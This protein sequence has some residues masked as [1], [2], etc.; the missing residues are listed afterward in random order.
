[1]RVGQGPP[2][3]DA[4]LQLIRQGLSF[5]IEGQRPCH[6]FRPV[7]AR[8]DLHAGIGVVPRGQVAGHLHDGRI[9]QQQHD[10]RAVALAAHDR[11]GLDA[12][13]T[14]IHFGAARKQDA[15]MAAQDGV[16]PGHAELVVQHAGQHGIFAADGIAV[17]DQVAGSHVI[18][19]D[20]CRH[21]ASGDVRFEGG[22]TPREGDALRIEA[23]HPLAIAPHFDVVDR[24]RLEF[25]IERDAEAGQFA[26]Q[27]AGAGFG[28]LF[29]ERHRFAAAAV[30]L[31]IEQPDAPVGAAIGGRLRRPCR[32]H[33]LDPYPF[34]SRTGGEAVVGT[35]RSGWKNRGQQARHAQHQRRK[36][37]FRKTPPP[38]SG[39]TM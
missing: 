27:L 2:L 12:E 6:H 11:L 26:D 19:H 34:G 29:V 18:D 22:F 21:H 28:D 9:L 20:Q 10:F 38:L 5:R 23:C 32:G 24:Q 14:H 3:R 37:S 36:E 25:G 4:L 39:A 13:G 33:R 7:P 31:G 17:A 35:H 8:T 30:H 1:M 15:D 16:V